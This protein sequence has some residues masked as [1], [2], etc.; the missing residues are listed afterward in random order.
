MGKELLLTE[1]TTK[2]LGSCQ[3]RSKTEHPCIHQA[4][5]EIHSIPFCKA[6]AHEQEAYF[7][8]GELTRETSRLA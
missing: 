7:A 5:V 2:Q 6:C 3:V 4:V 1:A 8:M